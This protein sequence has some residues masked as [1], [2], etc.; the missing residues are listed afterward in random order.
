MHRKELHKLAKFLHYVLGVRPDEFGLLPDPEGFV[1]VKDLLQALKEEPEWSFVGRGHVLELMHGPDRER[2][3]L[4]EDRIRA[5]APAAALSPEPVGAPPSRLYHGVR[6]RAHP[7]VLRHGLRPN[8]GPWVILTLTREMAERIARRRDPDPV[9]L[10][11]RAEE[12]TRK[13]VRFLGTQG[14]LFLAESLPPECLLGPPVRLD[15]EVSHAQRPQTQRPGQSAGSFVPDARRVFQKTPKGRD[16]R[17][18]DR[19][20]RER[21]RQERP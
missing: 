9:I 18:K 21:R 3:E 19:W 13:G 20:R 1:G 6:R 17:D 8:K 12:A 2:L 10:E 7:V 16:R 4:Q 11:V 5:T 14:L 15:E